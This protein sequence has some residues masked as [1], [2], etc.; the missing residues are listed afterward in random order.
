[1]AWYNQ[2]YVDKKCL[3]FNEHFSYAESRVVD[4]YIKDINLTLSPISTMW[5]FFKSKCPTAI[6]H[7]E[8]VSRM[9]EQ[10]CKEFLYE[11]LL[12]KRYNTMNIKRIYD[13]W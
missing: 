10:F 2:L 6:T 13:I 1:M 4:L 5:S 7:N 9:L 8:P 12:I 3:D 11:F